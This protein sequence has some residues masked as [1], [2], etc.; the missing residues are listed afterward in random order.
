MYTN[1]CGL[2]LSIDDLLFMYG[3]LLAAAFYVYLISLL[4]LLSAHE[5]T[6]VLHL[7]FINYDRVLNLL[8]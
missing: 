3:G 7:I 4:A 5:L 6:L 2:G 1:S 8:K